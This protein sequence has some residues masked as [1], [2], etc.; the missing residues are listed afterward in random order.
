M[1][2]DSSKA[3]PELKGAIKGRVLT[4]QDSEYDEARQIWNAMIDR[5]PAAIVQPASAADI[6]PAIRL[7][8]THGLEIS[9]RGGGHNIAGNA[10]CNGGLTI[11]FSRMR[12][13][14][15]DSAQ[16]RAYVEP[17]ATLG[18]FDSATQQ[19]GLRSEEHTSELQ[20]QF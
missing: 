6:A 18:D 15:V 1:R 3:V 19:F 9:I 2:A 16:K 14:R 5:R 20:S 8:R 10:L 4:P 7:A 11:D 13:V 12:G 17:G